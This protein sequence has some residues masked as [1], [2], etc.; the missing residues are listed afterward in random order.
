MS[1]QLFG[2]IPVRDFDRA[3]DWYRRFFGSEPSFL[4]N[5]IEAVWGLADAVYLY[6]EVVPE[7]AG[8][9][10][11]MLLVEQLDEVVR[12]LEQRGFVPAEVESYAEGQMRKFIYRDPE[13]NEVSYGGGPGAAGAA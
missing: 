13:G 5:D 9:A 1:T 12:G 3:L 6:I 7:R 11:H 10:R 8:M 2:C 4:P